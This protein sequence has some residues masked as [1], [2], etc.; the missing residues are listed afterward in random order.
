MD[1]WQY[2]LMHHEYDEFRRK[3]DSY[4]IHEYYY[5]EDEKNATWTVDPVVVAGNSPEEVKEI[6]LMMLAALEANGVKDYDD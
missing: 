4:A 2:Q 3:E 1:K 5:G 6:L